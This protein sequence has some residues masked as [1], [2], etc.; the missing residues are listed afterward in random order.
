[1]KG[2]A[3]ESKVISGTPREGG[4]L[5]DPRSA[6]SDQRRKTKREPE[7]GPGVRNTPR[8]DHQGDLHACSLW[9]VQVRL[10]W[11]G[12]GHLRQSG[13]EFEGCRSVLSETGLNAQ[14]KGQ[15][16]P[17]ADTL[18]RH[19]RQPLIT[20]RYFIYHKDTVELL[21]ISKYQVLRSTIL[22]SNHGIIQVTTLTATGAIHLNSPVLLPTYAVGNDLRVFHSRIRDACL[23]CPVI[24]V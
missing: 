18:W 17:G 1:M 2:Q 3:R 4:C 13:G 14:S 24:V 22:P 21:E 16:T 5:R 20:G 10:W 19:Y 23:D 7:T 8:A 12:G 15:R 11:P 9:S 6:C